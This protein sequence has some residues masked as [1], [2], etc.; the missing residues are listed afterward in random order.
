HYNR[1]NDPVFTQ[2]ERGLTT[3][4]SQSTA[5]TF[6]YALEDE[7][8]ATLP[9]LDV[10]STQAPYAYRIYH[11]DSDATLNGLQWSG[12]NVLLGIGWNNAF[13]FLNAQL[14]GAPV[15]NPAHPV[16]IKYGIK[17][18]VLDSPN[19]IT[20]Q[21]LYDLETSSSS[22]DTLNALANDDLGFTGDLPWMSSIPVVT[23][24][25]AT[26]TA[27][28]DGSICTPDSP[29]NGCQELTI[30]LRPD[31]SW[32]A[33]LDGAIPS[34]PVTP[35]DVQFSTLLA[36]DDPGSFISGAYF[37]LQNVLSHA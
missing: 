33:S 1:Y 10:W 11:S 5:Q 24:T 22:Y 30:I 29:A 6:A 34:L 26:N 7:Y 15:H 20:Q 16:F 32:A 3:A 17:T 12:I 28:S 9:A 2:A 13:S 36:R 21:F 27:F 37:D 35:D 23:R 8:N 4:P 14:I 25:V 31:L 19:P 18:D